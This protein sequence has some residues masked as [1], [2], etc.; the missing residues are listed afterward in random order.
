MK[1]KYAVNKLILVTMSDSNRVFNKWRKTSHEGRI[2]D[3]IISLGRFFEACSGVV[4]DN[5]VM[6]E[7]A[8]L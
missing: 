3:K 4:E 8:S 1:K 2:T 7:N 6:F 5:N